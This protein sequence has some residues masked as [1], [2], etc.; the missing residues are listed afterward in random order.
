MISNILRACS[1]M[2]KFSEICSV[3]NP[4]GLRGSKLRKSQNM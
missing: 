2:R 3:E 1:L 4:K